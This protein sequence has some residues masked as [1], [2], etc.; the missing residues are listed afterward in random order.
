MS[1]LDDCSAAATNYN[2]NSCGETRQVMMTTKVTTREQRMA[3]G[4]IK[5]TVKEEVTNP[6]GSI[7]VTVTET[8]TVPNAT[9]A[10]TP[11]PP[12]AV[13]LQ[14]TAIVGEDPTDPTQEVSASTTASTP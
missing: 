3:D 10:A 6:N 1:D 5:T 2:T 14:D 13:V 7:T 11:P 12:R 8:T 4:S 9:A